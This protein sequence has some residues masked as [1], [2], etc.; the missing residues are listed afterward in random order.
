MGSGTELQYLDCSQ[1][2]VRSGRIQP[3]PPADAPHHPSTKGGGSQLEAPVAYGAVILRC[4]AAP[5]SAFQSGGVLV[6]LRDCQTVLI[7]SR[8]SW[9]HWSA[10]FLSSPDTQSMQA[11]SRFRQV[12]DTSNVPGIWYASA[13][14]VGIC[15]YRRYVPRAR[16]GSFLDT[17]TAKSPVSAG[18]DVETEAEETSFISNR[19]LG[20]DLAQPTTL[21]AVRHPNHSAGIPACLASPVKLQAGPGLSS[22]T[23]LAVA[24]ETVSSILRPFPADSGAALNHRLR[25]RHLAASARR[26]HTRGTPIVWIKWCHHIW[27]YSIMLGPPATSR[28]PCF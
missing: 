19:L 13:G 5:R 15:Y 16:P 2:L 28:R 21:S 8:C 6:V 22:E 1:V 12:H 26:W 27:R 7:I 3:S 23:R 14:V 18:L 9:R 10:C 25:G 11:E 20:A 17:T 4:G 24:H